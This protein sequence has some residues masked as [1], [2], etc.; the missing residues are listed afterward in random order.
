MHFFS[1][2]VYGSSKVNWLYDKETFE[3][4]AL[5]CQGDEKKLFFWQHCFFSFFFFFYVTNKT[6]ATQHNDSNIV[7][8]IVNALS[9]Y[10]AC[11]CKTC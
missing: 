4:C 3:K 7:V 1:L 5:K 9:F 10:S 2:S 11:G 6:M 8:I